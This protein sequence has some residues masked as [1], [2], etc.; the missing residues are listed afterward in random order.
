MNADERFLS[1]RSGAIVMGLFLLFAAGAWG[2]APK[3]SSDPR[4]A[5]GLKETSGQEHI[6][7]LGHLPLEGIHVNQMFIQQRGDKT[8]LYLH[9]PNAQA[10]ALVDVTKP[11]NPTLINRAD[12][13]GGFV[14]GTASGSVLAI[15]VTPENGSNQGSVSTL[16]TETVHFLDMSDPKNPKSV[17]SF[18]GVTAVYPDDSRK[19]VYLVNNEGLWIVSHRMT[20][21]LPLC[22]SESALTPEPDCQ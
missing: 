17:K 3:A 11:D 21:P 5:S 18:Q 6:R 15:N 7:V 8:Y 19:L 2:Q 1:S 12:I 9:R 14:E 4:T 22:N 16:P 20:H 13:K 10:Y